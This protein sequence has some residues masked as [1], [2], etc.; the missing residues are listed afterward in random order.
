MNSIVDPAHAEAAF[1]IVGHGAELQPVLRAIRDGQAAH[2]YLIGG[3]PRIGKGLAARTIAAAFC[4][5]AAEPPCGRCSTCR[6]VAAGAHP[7]VETLSP[8]GICDESDHDHATDRSRDI[9]ICQVRRAQR[10]LNLA[11][12]ESPARVTIA[13]PADALNT[14]SVDAFLKTLEEPPA[15]ARIILVAAHPARLPETV[16]SRC[17]LVMLR[18]LPVRTVERLLQETRGLNAADAALL[19]RLSGGRIGRALE[20]ATDPGA[21]EQRAT[22]LEVIE[23]TARD[24]ATRWRAAE[25]LAAAFGR[26]RDDV[27]E[28][29][30]LWIDWWRDVV[31]IAAGAEDRIVN[32]DRIDTLRWAAAHF[33]LESVIRFLRALL[34]TGA[35][36]DRNVNPRLALDGLMLRLPASP[37]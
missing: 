37:P 8:G 18:T 22:R 34:D 33:P 21:L 15:G 3:P 35:D 9:R 2:A 26:N 31:L 25:S 29:L 23:Q 19:A 7:D 30:A 11:P 6:R 28:S 27:H 1:T 17:R 5:R 13:D 12:F 4:C 36:L 32:I 16:R 20:A 24:R 14:Q 10:L